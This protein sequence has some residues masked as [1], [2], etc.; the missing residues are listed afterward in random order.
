M[1]PTFRK[2][3]RKQAKARLALIGTAGSGKTY[4]ALQ[5]AR[6]LAGPTGRIA[7]IDTERGSASLYSDLT[8]FDTMD[9]HPPYNPKRL[10]EALAVAAEYDVLIIDSLSHFWNGEGGILEIVDQTPGKSKFTS[11]WRDA[12]PLQNKMVN[13]ILS[14]PGHVIV[15]MRT[16]TAYVLTT[17]SKGKQEP[18]KVGM[19]PVQREGMDFEF[20]VV[21]EMTDKHALIVQKSRCPLLAER[22]SYLAPETELFAS[23][24]AGWLAGGGV[25]TITVNAA[26][27]QLFDLLVQSKPADEA[28]A[29]AISYWES[30]KVTDGEVD[31][32]AF[33]ALLAQVAADLREAAEAEDDPFALGEPEGDDA[34]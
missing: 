13:A 9:M 6:T 7:V 22:G 23:D 4:T 16:K 10:V 29:L 12:T 27:R 11:G 17:N 25:P 14:F 30:V 2:A 1:K 3:E 24:F 19:A 33:A 20:T 26:K 28:K 15:T 8:D 5:I 31:K 32:E 34:K 21:A 18:T